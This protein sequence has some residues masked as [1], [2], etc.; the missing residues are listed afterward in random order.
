LENL[1]KIKRKLV[2]GGYDNPLLLTNLNIQCISIMK[3][4]DSNPKRLLNTTLG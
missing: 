3:M 4:N 2:S 1:Q